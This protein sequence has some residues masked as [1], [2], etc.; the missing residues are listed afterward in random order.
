MPKLGIKIAE[1]ECGK[2]D[3]MDTPKVICFSAMR[4]YEPSRIDFINTLAQ[5]FLARGMRS[6]FGAQCLVRPCYLNETDD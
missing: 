6:F 5:L 4:D 1:W 3:Q 2:I